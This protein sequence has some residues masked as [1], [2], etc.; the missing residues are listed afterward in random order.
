[1]KVE[2]LI[3]YLNRNYEGHENV[4]AFIVGSSFR[5]TKAGVWDKAV[6]IWDSENN[7]STFSDYIDDLIIDAEFS[8]Q[9]EEQAELAIDTYLAD[10]A[11]KELES[12]NV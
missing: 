1:M 5:E 4:M 7:L 10:L 12:E 11:E 8:I 2:N 3:A 9:Q 6:E